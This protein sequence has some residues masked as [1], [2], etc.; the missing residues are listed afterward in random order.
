MA[1]ETSQPLRRPTQPFGGGGARWVGGAAVVLFIGFAAAG[2][3]PVAYALAAL[4]LVVVVTLLA[5]RDPVGSTAALVDNLS[6]KAAVL[7][8]SEEHTSELQ[9]RQ[10]LVCRLLLGQK[11]K[12]EHSL[13]QHLASR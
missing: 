2:M 8:R 9:S 4:V 12:T 10:Y 5:G 7:P 13:Q 6:T 1:S 11:K 3:L